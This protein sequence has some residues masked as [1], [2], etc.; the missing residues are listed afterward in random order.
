MSE[1]ELA[2]AKLKYQWRPFAK[3][4][5]GELARRTYRWKALWALK[6]SRRNG[7]LVEKAL[8][9]KLFSKRGRG[10]T[11]SVWGQLIGFVLGR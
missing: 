8:V 4:F 2:A 10:T 11:G 5:F 1:A 3:V 9:L 7:L 6:A